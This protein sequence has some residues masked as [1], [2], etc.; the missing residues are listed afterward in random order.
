MKAI[1]NVLASERE[2]CAALQLTGIQAG[3]HHWHEEGEGKVGQWRS[4]EMWVTLLGSG[5]QSDLPRLALVYARVTNA[6]L[7]QERLPDWERVAVVWR[8]GGRSGALQYSDPLD[9]TGDPMATALQALNLGTG[10]PDAAPTS[11]MDL[12]LF[13][14]SESSSLDLTVG[15]EVPAHAVIERC[16]IDALTRI[17][18][19]NVDVRAIA[20]SWSALTK[21]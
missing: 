8:P 6:V 17:G 19:D 21:S 11:G 2:I 4:R 1:L 7:R 9:V 20:E 10:A 15:C 5:S 12:H 16:A 3:H 14:R 18:A 13:Y